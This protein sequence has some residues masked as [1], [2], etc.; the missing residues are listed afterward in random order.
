[1]GDLEQGHNEAVAALMVQTTDQTLLP[2]PSGYTEEKLYAGSDTDVTTEAE[3]APKAIKDRW[4]NL[5]T[6]GRFI[7]VAVLK[8]F[9]LP[10]SFG[11]V[12]LKFLCDKAITYNDVRQLDPEF[13]KYR[14]APLLEE[15]GV[16]SMNAALGEPLTFVSS[17]T[18]LVKPLPL[19]PNGES[20]EVSEE[21]KEEYLAKLSEAHLCNGRRRELTF[22]VEGFHEVIPLESIKRVG[23]TPNELSVLISGVQ[24]YDVAAWKKNAEV[25]SASSGSDVVGWFWEVLEGF[26]EE[27]RAKVLQFSTGS[28]RLPPKGFEDLNPKFKVVVTGAEVRHLPVSH[29]CVNQLDLPKYDSK[30]ELETKLLL[31]VQSSGSAG[32]GFA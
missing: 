16:Q 32:F 27:K 6:V 17:A 4:Y 15:G 22:F 8:K 28:S 12:L 3:A 21:N 5:A 30:E 13:F 24:T 25:N 31:A 26:D 14:V 9:P 10:L 29:T 2:R 20:T 18:D 11:N 23:L 1:M 19:I 7:A